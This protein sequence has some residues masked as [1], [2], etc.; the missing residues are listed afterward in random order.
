MTWASGGSKIAERKVLGDAR[1]TPG[2]GHWGSPGYKTTG[3]KTGLH[4]RLTEKYRKEKANCKIP[5]ISLA[6]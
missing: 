1:G 6:S 2:S 4:R 5:Q 3:F